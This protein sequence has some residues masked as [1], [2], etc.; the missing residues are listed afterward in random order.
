MF[1][2]IAQSLILKPLHTQPNIRQVNFFVVGPRQTEPINEKLLKWLEQH[3]VRLLPV[4]HIFELFKVDWL[5]TRWIL[6]EIL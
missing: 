1:R 3:Q 5:R 4:V 6:L 2:R